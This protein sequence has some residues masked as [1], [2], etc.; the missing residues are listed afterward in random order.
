MTVINS[1]IARG[2]GTLPKEISKDALVYLDASVNVGRAFEWET[3]SKPKTSKA[4]FSSPILAT[5]KFGPLDVYGVY[6][7]K[8]WINRNYCKCLYYNQCLFS[9]LSFLSKGIIYRAKINKHI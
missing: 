9:F 7:I 6:L 1:T 3:L 2:S 8:L 5:T 4:V